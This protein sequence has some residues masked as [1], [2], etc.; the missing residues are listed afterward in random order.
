MHFLPEPL[1]TQHLYQE[2]VK[3]NLK[4]DVVME[5]KNISVDRNYQQNLQNNFF[6]ILINENAFKGD[7]NIDTVILQ[8]DPI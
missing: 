2:C 6:D 7:W 8:H 3:I 5:I 1:N 4:L